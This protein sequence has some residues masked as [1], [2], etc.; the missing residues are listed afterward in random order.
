MQKQRHLRLQELIRIITIQS[1]SLNTLNSLLLA[2]LPPRNP[3]TTSTRPQV[4]PTKPQSLLNSLTNLNHRLPVLALEASVGEGAGGIG[5]AS[6]ERGRRWS[7]NVVFA[8]DG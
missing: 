2:P 3:I 5:F 6:G 1:S 4:F 7:W 8:E